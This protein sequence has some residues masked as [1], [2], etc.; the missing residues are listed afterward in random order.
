[1]GVQD[2]RGLSSRQKNPENPPAG[3]SYVMGSLIPLT[4]T[5][6]LKYSGGHDLLKATMYLLNLEQLHLPGTHFCLRQ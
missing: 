1:M 6:W 4:A 3:G 5:P 2:C